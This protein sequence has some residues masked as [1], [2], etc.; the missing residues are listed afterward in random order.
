MN[1]TRFV[2]VSLIQLLNKGIEILLHT[3]KGRMP[4]FLLRLFKIPETCHTVLN[5]HLLYFN[6]GLLKIYTS[7][8]GI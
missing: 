4:T 2:K 7:E 6:L 3:K 5:T 1:D 8:E